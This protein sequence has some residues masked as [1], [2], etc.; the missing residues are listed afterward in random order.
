M[1]TEKKH[2]SGMKPICAIVLLG[3]GLALL[4]PV[5]PVPAAPQQRLA[6]VMAAVEPSLTVVSNQPASTAK[7]TVRKNATPVEPGQKRKARFLAAFGMVIISL[8][9]LGTAI[10]LLRSLRQH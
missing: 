8:L 10:A 7:A 2:A 1:L 4:A 9:A 6:M 5:Q 3:V